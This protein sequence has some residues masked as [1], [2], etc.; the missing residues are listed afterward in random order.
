MLRAQMLATALDVY[1]SDAGLGGNKIGAPAPLGGKAIDLAAICKM[2]DNSNG[3]GTCSGAYQDASAAFQPG[4][5]V[6]AAGTCPAP[7]AQPNG[8]KPMTVLCLLANAASNSA[9][10]GTPW[11]GTSKALQV[12]AKDTFDAINNVAAFA[13]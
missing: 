5:Y 4:T 1:F 6:D 7:V 2:S 9:P 13:P 10:T 8:S 3:S 12:L 11:Y